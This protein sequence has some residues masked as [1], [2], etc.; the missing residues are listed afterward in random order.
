MIFSAD[1]VLPVSGPPIP[2][3]AV[4]IDD[5]RIL[6][7]G[8]AAELGEGSRFTDAA[9]IPG[10]V[11][12][13][14]HLEYALYAGFGDGLPFG[15]W[16]G[17]HVER[18]SRIDLEDMEDIARLGAFE[19]LRSGI[20][21]VGDCSFSGAA[22]TACAELGLRGTIYLEVFGEGSDAAAERFGPMRERIAGALSERVRLGISPHAPYTCSLELYRACDELGLP[23]ATHLA[24]SEDENEFLRTGGGGWEAFADLLV[25]PLGTTGIRALAGAGLLGNNVLAAHCV[26][27]DDEEIALLAEH[28]VAVA[29]CPRSNA[30]LGLGIAPVA[31]LLAAGVRVGIGTD[32]PASTPSFDMFEELRTAVALARLRNGGPTAMSAERVLELATLGSAAALGLDEEV[33]SLEPGKHADVAVVGLEGSPYVPWEDPAAAVVMG[34]SAS[35]VLLTVVDGEVRYDAE[36]QRWQELQQKGIE[37]RAKLLGR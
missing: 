23:V 34:G 26:M 5:G 13:H 25:R 24:E 12:A 15:D 3:G 11:N 17:L 20:T 4:A 22:A 8:P 33:G 2:D 16:I 21:A 6:A 28:D 27:A 1:W 30:L 31:E 7:V 35:R 18:K 32:S 29:H 19:C 36:N 9:I 10:F 14:S 37:A